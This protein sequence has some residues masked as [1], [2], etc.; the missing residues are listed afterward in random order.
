VSSSKTKLS[1]ISTSPAIALSFSTLVLLGIVIL[2]LAHYS[3]IN[4]KKMLT[5]RRV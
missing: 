4:S 2:L 5:K 1:S 3:K